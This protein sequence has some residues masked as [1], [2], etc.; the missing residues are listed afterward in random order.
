M[1]RI[2]P[3]KAKYRRWYLDED[4]THQLHNGHLL[5]ISKG[6]RFD[7]HSVP[8]PFRLLFPKYNE[9]DIYAA[10][11][12]DAL[13]DL[14]PWHRYPRKFMDK[15]YTILM[16]R[17]SHGRRKYWMPFAVWLYGWVRYTLW[18]DYRGEYDKYKTKVSVT[19]TM[20]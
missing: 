20:V 5:H 4:V 17:Y 15:E 19:V 2:I 9:Q 6:Y 11:I 12:H 3:D 18:G 7:A 10:L 8:F 13:C 14:A 1:P 16:Q